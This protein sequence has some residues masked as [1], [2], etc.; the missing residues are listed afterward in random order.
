[1]IP[2][3]GN[4]EIENSA[5]IYGNIVDKEV[6]F[7]TP[8]ISILYKYIFLCIRIKHAFSFIGHI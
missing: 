1:M 8:L 6:N 5:G 7:I 3:I 4:V 2:A